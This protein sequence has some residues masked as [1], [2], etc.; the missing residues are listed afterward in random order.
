MGQARG[1]ASGRV[2]NNVIPRLGLGT[3]PLMGKEAEEVVGMA[4]DLG[5]RHIDTAQM[6]GNEAAVGKALTRSGVPRDKVFVVTKVDPGNLSAARFAPSVARSVADLGGPVDLLLIHW[7]PPDDE[8]DATVDRLVA[9]LE[10]GEARHIG[11]SNFTIAMMEQAQRRAGGRIICNQVEFHPLID[12]RRVL[13]A[14]QRF[15]ISLTAYSPL[16]RGKV[17]RAEAVSAIAKKLGRPA[18][19]IVLRWIIQQDVAAIPKSGRRDNLR[20]NLNALS[21]SLSEQDMAAIAALASPSGRTLSR[22]SMQGRWDN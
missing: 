19:E 16:A 11:V 21:F 9:A 17:L 8:I 20:S 1:Q 7:P 18:S 13:A 14:A 22:S 10:R 3:Y 5:Y 12:Q 4:I 15:N 6:Y 2:S